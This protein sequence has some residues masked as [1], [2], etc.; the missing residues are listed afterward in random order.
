MASPQVQPA[1]CPKCGGVRLLTD[2][3]EFGLRSA[4]VLYCT[5]CAYIEFYASKEKLESLAQERIAEQEGK[6]EQRE[7]WR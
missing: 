2:G 3:G 5:S 6:T 1:P 7:R 4:L